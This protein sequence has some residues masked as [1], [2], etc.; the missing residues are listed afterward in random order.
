MTKKNASIVIT[1]EAGGIKSSEKNKIPSSIIKCLLSISSLSTK[2][3]TSFYL[4]IR[5][6]NKHSPY[7]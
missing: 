5:R 3:F 6:L 4:K 7:E 2:T 1:E